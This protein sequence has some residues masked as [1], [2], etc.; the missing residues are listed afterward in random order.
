MSSLF[1]V[2]DL[3]GAPVLVEHLEA[4]ARAQPCEGSRFTQAP[5]GGAG[6]GHRGGS[7]FLQD[8]R[9]AVAAGR[10][11]N[12]A[13]LLHDLGWSRDESVPPSEAQLF[14]EAY[15]RWGKD[16]PARLDGDWAFA[17]WDAR[18]R[19]LA[20]LRDHHGNTALYWHA[21]GPRLAFA[22]SL[23]ALLALLWVPRRPDLFRVA[24]V[25]AAWSGD[26]VRTAYE[27]IS[28]L[29]PGHGLEAEGRAVRTYR[30]WFPEALPTFEGLADEAYVEAF[31]EAYR[32]AVRRRLAGDGPVGLLLSGGLD[33]GS[34][35]ALAGPCLQA[36]GRSLTAITAVP[37]EAPGGI[38]PEGLCFDEGPTAAATA[39]RTGAGPHVL[40][41]G[42]GAGLLRSLD[43]QVDL[44]LQPGHAA[45]NYPWLL[46]ALEEARRRGIR[47]LLTGQQGN[48]TVS[49]AGNASLV[50]PA[51][52]Q[53]RL[54][55]AWRSLR[56]AEAGW[57]ASLE[58]QVARPLADP[59][60]RALRASSRG[61]EPW[62]AY[63]ALNPGLARELRLRERMAEAGHDPAFEHPAARANLDLLDPGRNAVGAVWHELG[64]AFGME[65][66][67]PT[68]DRRL[69]EFCLRCPELQY[70]RKGE[71]R[72]LLRRA[73]KDLLP[74]EV[75]FGRRAGRQSAEV[76]WWALGER[77][78]IRARLDA[79]GG[80]P[81]AARCLDLPGMIRVLEGLAPENAWQAYGAVGGNLAR[82]LAVGR[83][84]SGF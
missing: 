77:D 1:G 83:F 41:A 39:R 59:I 47:I 50:W 16:C 40:V 11:D 58:W 51:L 19:N 82:G 44:H 25:L 70:R 49:H 57:A 72:W 22:S 24:Q 28:A 6:F 78:A 36:D 37:G 29:P 45:A 3:D 12:R 30:Y 27:A 33:S 75:L 55:L 81:L 67:D 38:E 60:R 26:G 73:F 62:S 76:G 8:G 63:A 61:P 65:V 54:G 46:A 43:R 23:G 74:P 5:G 21:E 7:T 64:E 53:G 2:V 56:G 20:L 18:T 79:L 84:L 10:L 4:M 9:L 42:S 31:L 69:A 35:A 34:V 48:A 71:A 17:V 14:L 32:G 52:R 68:A 80:H 66:R 13:E 15:F